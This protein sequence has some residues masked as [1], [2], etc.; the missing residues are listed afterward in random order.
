MVIIFLNRLFIVSYFLD[1]L[2]KTNTDISQI[3]FLIPFW[4]KLFHV[5]GHAQIHIYDDVWSNEELIHQSEP[6]KPKP[7]A[8]NA[9][10]RRSKVWFCVQYLINKNE[11]I[12][13]LR[14]VCIST[15]GEL[16]S[17]CDQLG[18]NDQDEPMNVSG[19]SIAL[20]HPVGMS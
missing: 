1:L 20:D 4:K 19:R 12:K 14:H 13:Y 10:A 7:R 2:G 5:R 17:R 18:L 3:H 6:T 16:L 11:I 15:I 8:N 9:M